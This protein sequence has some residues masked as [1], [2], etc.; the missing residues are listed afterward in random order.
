MKALRAINDIICAFVS[1]QTAT[2]QAGALHPI[3]C[4]SAP[5]CRGEKPGKCFGFTPTV[6][7]GKWQYDCAQG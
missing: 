5:Y 6:F 4:N 2:R 1:T 3:T 7:P